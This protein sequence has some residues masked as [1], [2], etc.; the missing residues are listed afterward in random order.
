MFL[1]LRLR[2]F[3][4]VLACAAQ[5]SSAE[6]I[7]DSAQEF[8][9]EVRTFYRQADGLPSDDVLDVLVDDQGKVCVQTS[10]GW[11]QRSGDKWLECDAPTQVPTLQLRSHKRSERR[12][13][14]LDASL[15]P[16]SE[17]LPDSLSREFP[18]DGQQ[19]WLVRDACVVQ[20]GLGR[21]WFAAQ[22]GVGRY[23]DGQWQFFTGAEGL[24]SNEFTCAAAADDG[25]VWFGTRHGVVRF[26]GQSWAYRQGQRWLADDAV[27]AIAVDHEGGAWIA[28]AAGLSHIHFVPMTLK[29]KAEYYENEIDEHHRRTE[30]GYVIE[31]HTDKPGDKSV[32]HRSDSDNDGLWTAMYGA[33]EC[34]AYAATKDPAARQ[35]AKDAFEALRYLSLAPRGGSHPAPKGFIARTIVP[36]DEPDPNQRPSYTLKGQEQT[37]QRGDSLWRVYEPRWPTSADGKYYWKSDTSSDELDGHYFFYAL[38]Y[39]LVAD[40]EEEK[41]LVREIVRDNADHIVENNFQMIDHAGVTRWAV[42]NPELFNQDVLWAAGR[43]LNSLS[44]LSYLATATHITGDPKYLE[45]AR[46]L[47]DVHGYHQ[48]VMVPKIQTGMGTGNQSDDEMAFMCFYNLIRYEPDAEL[49]KRYLFAFWLYWRLEQPEINPFFNFTYAAVSAKQN[50]TNQWASYSLEPSDGW[51]TDSIDTLQRYPLDRFNWAH[52]NSHRI[53]ILSLPQK[54]LGQRRPTGYRNNGKVI[55]V[56][57]SFSEHLNHSPWALNTGGDGRSLGDGTVYLLPYYMGR[58]HG[59]IE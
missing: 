9:Q 59:F 47:R 30:F 42:F 10:A 23:A 13:G 32:T 26:D 16:W 45:A 54:Y 34:Y 31:A 29:E 20:D 5:V 53:D 38:Y 33:G 1:P 39:D 58:Y 8:P 4:V 2:I 14:P 46:E 6:P 50:Y 24:P 40:T 7:A 37:R 11:V 44:I 49:R 15:L 22:Q 55:P 3:F 25:T 36:I 19:A 17:R 57:E 52:D 51:L 28:T 35:R 56:D 18:S 48:N 41:E 12:A 43:G 21:Y 27:R